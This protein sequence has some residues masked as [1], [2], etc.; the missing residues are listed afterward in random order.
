M[1][2]HCLSQFIIDYNRLQ[3]III[4]CHRLS[5]FV[6]IYHRFSQIVIVYQH[7]SKFM[8]DNHNLSQF[9]NCESPVRSLHFKAGASSGG[10]SG[11]GSQTEANRIF[12][13]S[14]YSEHQKEIFSMIQPSPTQKIPSR[15]LTYLW[16]IRFFHGKKSTI[17][18]AIFHSN[19]SHY[20]RV[21]LQ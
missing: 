5:E 6:V 16:K 7:L 21:Y 12:V 15:N 1:N 3:Q 2:Y 11:M 8:I 20:Q 14:G 18:M 10:S 13:I 17:S 9:M 19:V 4:D